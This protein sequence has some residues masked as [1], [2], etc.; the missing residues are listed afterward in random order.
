MTPPDMTPPGPI[1]VRQ[2]SLRDVADGVE[3]MRRLAVFEGHAS[4]FTA[5]PERLAEGL[6]GRVPGLLCWVAEYDGR[7]LGVALCATTWVGITCRPS[8]RLLNLVVDDAVRGRGIGTRLM[9]AVAAACVELDC[10]LD[11]MVRTENLPVQRFYLRLGAAPREEW[12]A[13]QLS[14][15]SI[16]ALAASVGP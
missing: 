6:F 15:E 8:I 10:S 12:Q 4:A 14:R 7:V 16:Q 2:A 3:L 13:W 9:A 11:W 5:T 1:V